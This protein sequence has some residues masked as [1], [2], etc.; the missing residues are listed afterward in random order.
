MPLSYAFIKIISNFS[1]TSVFQFLVKFI[2]YFA[3]FNLLISVIMFI[4]FFYFLKSTRPL[5]L[6]FLLLIILS[7]S[8]WIHVLTRLFSKVRSSWWIFLCFEVCFVS[9]F[10]LWKSHSFLACFLPLFCIFCS[11]MICLLICHGA[12][13]H[14]VH[15]WAI[16]F[17]H[18][19]LK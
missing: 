4:A 9:H 5:F 15:N 10:F 2:F 12:F 13:F 1:S 6:Y 16:L 11:A 18:F 7:L 3:F 19:F 17:R 14:T 8:S